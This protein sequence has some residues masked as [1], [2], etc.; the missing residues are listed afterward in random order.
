MIYKLEQVPVHL[1]PSV[2]HGAIFANNNHLL[3]RGVHAIMS[4]LNQLVALFKQYIITRLLCDEQVAARNLN[5]SELALIIGTTH[6]AMAPPTYARA[7][8][9]GQVHD[10][11]VNTSGFEK[12]DGTVSFEVV[13]RMIETFM[14]NEPNT[15]GVVVPTMKYK[16]HWIDGR[17]RE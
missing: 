3:N 1:R 13:G 4:S 12:E 17:T 9:A 15:Q 7:D 8:C 16:I 2:S 11:V 5:D 6:M 10:L 14:K